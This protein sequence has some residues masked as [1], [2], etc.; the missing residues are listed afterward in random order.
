MEITA[1]AVQTVASNENVI[2]TDTA[3]PRNCAI[4]HRDGSGLVSLRGLT[5]QFRARFKITFGANIA[6]VTS[7]AAIRLAFSLDGEPLQETVMIVTPAAINEYFNVSKS[8]YLDVPK[9][10]NY[11]ISV[12]NISTQAITVQNANM[13][14]ERVA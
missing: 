10:T 9:G 5:Q 1:V 2:F 8:F 14:I 11:V 12:K 7:G 4:S 13:L 3:V 6:A